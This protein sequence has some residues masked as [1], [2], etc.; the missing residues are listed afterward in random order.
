MT[1]VCHNSPFLIISIFAFQF[2]V[3]LGVTEAAIDFN[4]AGAPS[5][6]KKTFISLC[7]IG[8]LAINVD[9]SPT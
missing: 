7:S 5:C 9:P 6:A 1:S 8:L 3:Q 2:G 4:A